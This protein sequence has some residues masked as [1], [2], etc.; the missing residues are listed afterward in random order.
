MRHTIRGTF[1]ANTE[2]TYG[3][4]TYQSLLDR[5]VPFVYLLRN[6]KAY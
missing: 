4:S 2:R 6:G 3:T 1:M 5:F